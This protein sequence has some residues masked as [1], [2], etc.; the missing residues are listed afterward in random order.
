MSQRCQDIAAVAADDM[1]RDPDLR[2]CFLVHLINLWE[3]NLVP[4]A[5]VDK[6]MALTSYVQV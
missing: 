2:R 5:V 6:C 1:Q 3:F 4:A